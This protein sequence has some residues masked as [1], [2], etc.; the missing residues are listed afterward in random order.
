VQQLSRGDLATL[1]RLVNLAIQ[2]KDVREAL[3]AGRLPP[4]KWNLTEQGAETLH[5]I[6]PKELDALV[7]VYQKMR[8]AGASK[9]DLKDAI[10]F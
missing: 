6:T 10:I 2:D 1:K 3:A 8:E 5:S 7:S 9:A 4:G